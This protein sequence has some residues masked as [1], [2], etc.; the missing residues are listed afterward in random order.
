MTK[1][2]L[3]VEDEVD[4]LRMLE[5]ILKKK[6]FEVVSTTDGPEALEAFLQSKPDLV[7]LDWLLPSANGTEV[8][9]WMR[10]K[11]NLRHVPIILLTATAEDVEKKAK[12]CMANSYFLKP[13]DYE[14]LL[15]EIE[16]LIG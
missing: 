8:S 1:K 6:D 3:V 12:E 10:E 4:I 11:S 13:F 15:K 5:F 16:R 7:I 2:I 14:L 9:R